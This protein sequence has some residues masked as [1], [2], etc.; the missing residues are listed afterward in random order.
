MC[1]AFD[2]DF[3]RRLCYIHST[4]YLSR[5]GLNAVG[6]DQYRRIPCV[7]TTTQLFTTRTAG[8]KE[9]YLN[10]SDDVLICFGERRWEQLNENYNRH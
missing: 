6:V 10:E 5:L 7:T 1:Y 3:I 9:Q 4:G 8:S 2:F